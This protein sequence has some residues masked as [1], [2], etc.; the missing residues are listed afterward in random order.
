MAAPA[1]RSAPFP[2]RAGAGRG[3]RA[4]ATPAGAMR[5]AEDLTVRV[6]GVPTAAAVE[7]LAAG[8]AGIDIEVAIGRGSRVVN[9][10]DGF[11]AGFSSR[12]LAF[13]GRVKPDLAAP[14]IGIATS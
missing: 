11:V 14:G 5:V 13:D 4:P 12:G 6:V 7:L 9:E 2:A 8:R 1:R 3:R 10:S